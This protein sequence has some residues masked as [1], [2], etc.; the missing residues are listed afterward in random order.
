MIKILAFSLFLTHLLQAQIEYTYP[1]DSGGPSQDAISIGEEVTTIYTFTV[2]ENETISKVRLRLAASHSWV[3]DMG[4]ALKSPNGTIVRL[5]SGIGFDGG[6]QQNTYFNEVI[7][8]ATASE[9]IGRPRPWPWQ[10]EYPGTDTGPWSGPYLP[11][12]EGDDPA[13]Y[14]LSSFLDEPSAG[15]WQLIVSDS[16]TNHTGYIYAE[17]DDT[18]ALP[19]A[20]TRFGPTLGTALFIQYSLNPIAEWRLINFGSS[21][22]SGSGADT[23]D[24]DQDGLSNLLEYALDRDPKSSLAA[25]GSAAQPTASITSSPDQFIF[26]MD[27]PASPPPDVIYQV[28]HSENLQDWFSIASKSGAADWDYSGPLEKTGLGDRERVEFS[29]NTDEYPIR[30]FRLSVSEVP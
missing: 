19:T 23:S 20:Q 8:A 12:V 1:I 26:S 9:D 28:Q 24:W 25:N 22:N 3:T 14:S 29:F 16:D 5:F 18:D 7:F 13:A 11:E 15:I 4:V 2:A 6:G 10:D 21:A 30:M 27:L 17:G